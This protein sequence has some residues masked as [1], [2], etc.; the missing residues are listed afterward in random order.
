M[1]FATVSRWLASACWTGSGLARAA[2][3]ASWRS[4][5]V[6]HVVRVGVSGIAGLLRA[7]GEVFEVLSNVLPTRPIPDRAGERGG[8]DRY[9]TQGFGCPPQGR[10]LVAGDRRGGAC[11]DR[12]VPPGAVGVLNTALDDV[13]DLG[14]CGGGQD[15]VVGDLVA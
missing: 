12:P 7:V 2:S 3:A 1:L 13:G 11:G 5:A 8:V 15:E 4:L 10:R 14:G 9:P 6:G